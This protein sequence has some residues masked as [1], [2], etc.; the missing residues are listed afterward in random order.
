MT[1]RGIEIFRM[2]VICLWGKTPVKRLCIKRSEIDRFCSFISVVNSASITFAYSCHFNHCRYTTSCQNPTV[3][4]N[5]MRVLGESERPQN[6]TVHENC[7][8]ML[9]ESESCQDATL[10]KNRV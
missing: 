8:R 6:A 10:C 5:R 1:M 9:G 4:E 3:C 7:V 2:L